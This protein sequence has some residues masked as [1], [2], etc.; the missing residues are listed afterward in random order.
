MA[1]IEIFGTDNEVL[2]D[3]NF[4]NM[5]VFSKFTGT[6]LPDA[7]TTVQ[8]GYY[9]FSYNSGSNRSAAPQLAV[10]ASFLTSLS[11]YE[12][13]GTVHTW[14]VACEAA[15]R[16]Q[17]ATF[18]LMYL[19]ETLPSTSAFVKL[20]NPQGVL[21]FDSD[22]QYCRVETLLATNANASGTFSGQ[23]GRTYAHILTVPCYQYRVV[24]TG[25][26]GGIGGYPTDLIF[27]LTG[28][29]F[30]GASIIFQNFTI[31]YQAVTFPSSS[32]PSFGTTINS[33]GVSLIID[34]T[35]Y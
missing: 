24:P 27:I 3:N 1:K 8:G 15:G 34:V 31:I 26:G 33:P 22:Q 29:K 11:Y 10:S 16:N 18:Y 28:I 23:A 6:F 13:S 25:S 30:V 35:G 4:K 17:T 2:I 12:V 20:Y 32:P 19:P 9:T 7:S 21:V 14:R 5:I